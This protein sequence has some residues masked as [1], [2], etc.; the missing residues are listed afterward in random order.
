[1]CRRSR[2]NR[3][4][5]SARTQDP[6]PWTRF[7]M[8]YSVTRVWRARWDESRKGPIPYEIGITVLGFRE[9]IRARYWYPAYEE[10]MC[11]GCQ[12][13]NVMD[14]SEKCYESP[15]IHVLWLFVL[16]LDVVCDVC[17]SWMFLGP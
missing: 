12:A 5:D 11:C 2:M 1:M 16:C 3:L 17:G 10:K 8:L 9:Y 14:A 13:G 4:S 6:A 15:S 7:V